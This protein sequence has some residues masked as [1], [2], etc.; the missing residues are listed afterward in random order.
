M[1]NLKIEIEI[2]Q[3]VAAKLCFNQYRVNELQWSSFI[4]EYTNNCGN[5]V[6]KL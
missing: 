4:R 3:I 6:R 5:L 2:L 1:V